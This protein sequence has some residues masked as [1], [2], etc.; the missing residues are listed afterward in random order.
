MRANNPQRHG[1]SPVGARLDTLR[2]AERQTP[3]A[4]IIP[5]ARRLSLRWP[6]GGGIY[7]WPA[8]VEIQTATGTRRTL[9]IPVQTVLFV[10]LAS[11]SLGALVGS[12]AQWS[13]NQRQE[14]R[15]GNGRHVR[16][17]GR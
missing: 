2:G 9:I 1:A 7:A 16:S 8:A 3:D 17:E 14:R 13:L 4:T 5:I 11:V 10:A 6:G 12:I 15:D